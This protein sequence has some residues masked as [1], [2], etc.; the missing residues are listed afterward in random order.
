M[1]AENLNNFKKFNDLKMPNRMVIFEVLGIREDP[2]NFGRK[3]VPSVALRTFDMI[4]VDG[5]PK[6]IASVERVDHEG[7]AVLD[8]LIFTGLNHGRIFLDPNNPADHIRYK[9]MTLCNYNASNPD[10]NPNVEPVFRLVDEE[11]EAKA[12]LEIEAKDNKAL[13]LFF[14]LKDSEVATIGGL[15]GLQ[16]EDAVMKVNL[17]NW[18]KENPNKF[19]KLVNGITEIAPEMEMILYGLKNQLL[20][21]NKVTREILYGP[22]KDK[23]VFSYDGEEVDLIELGTSLKKDNPEIIKG[24]KALSKAK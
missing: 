18:L 17:L 11:K 3:I 20:I 9:Y 2:E 12:K 1:K 5:E 22:D 13:E 23:V 16:G 21:D 14:V 24:L 10:R 8:I 15:I 4:M 7:V 19:T 6:N